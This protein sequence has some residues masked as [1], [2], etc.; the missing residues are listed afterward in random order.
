VNI[1]G[2]VEQ[3][4]GILSFSFRR[5]SSPN[6]R[7][8][9]CDVRGVVCLDAPG[10]VGLD[11]PGV[12]GLDA[13]GDTLHPDSREENLPD[14][15]GGVLAP[16]SGGHQFSS[17]RVPDTSDAWQ[18]SLLRTTGLRR[19]IPGAIDCD[20]EE[21]VVFREL[22]GGVLVPS[23]GHQ[24]SDL[25]SSAEDEAVDARLPITIG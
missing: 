17:C 14:M 9:A 5:T 25:G 6:S 7:N 16:D 2:G 20:H 10:V 19:I 13:A 24:L 3:R 4:R 11:A 15:R 18:A 23:G 1:W 21:P 22:L 8:E 12:V